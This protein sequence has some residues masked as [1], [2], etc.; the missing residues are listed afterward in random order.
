MGC[1][2][3]Q[4][5]VGGKEL[6]LKACE[7]GSLATTS[8]SATITAAAAHGLKVGDLVKFQEV[9]TL[10]TFNTTSFYFVKT[11]P[12]PT[13]FTL[14]ATPSGSS[15]VADATTSA[16]AA[17]LYK[18]LGGLRSKTFAFASEAIDIT[19][20]DSDEYKKI[21]NSAG[22]RSFNVS[23]SGVYTN[24]DVFQDVFTKARANEL[25]CLM[26]I[27][28]KALRVFE[29]CFKITSLEVGGDY[30]AESNYS[31]SA[32]SSGTLTVFEAA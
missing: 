7:L 8:A 12:S 31:I 11:V 14:S 16:L 10:T 19:N 3:T 30:D 9:D 28:V 24:E 25:V 23:G 18:S 29:G 17:D 6:L 27:D 2:T 32:E 15:I 1:N 4:N 26:L 22:I 13:T 20:Q 5:E 21:L